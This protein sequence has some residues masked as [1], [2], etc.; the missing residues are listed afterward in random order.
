M[1]LTSKQQ[2]AYDLVESGKTVFITGPGGCGKTYLI[3]YIQTNLQKRIAITALTGIAATLI[4]GQTLHSWAG[5]G[6]EK[7]PKEWVLGKI[8]SNVDTVS[9][10]QETELLIIDE[11]SMMSIELFNL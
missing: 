5:I 3:K 8:M 2:E 11:I 4:N 10:W 1:S 7:K 6:D 9:R